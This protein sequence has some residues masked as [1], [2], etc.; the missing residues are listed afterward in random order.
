M[1]RTARAILG[2]MLTLVLLVAAA[3]LMLTRS[4]FGRD[5]I[6]LYALSALR[7]SVNGHVEIGRIEGNVLGRFSLSDVSITDSAGQPFVAA[8]R[9]TATLDAGALLLRRITLSDVVVGKPEVHLTKTPDEAWNFARIFRR[10]DTTASVSSRGFGDWIRLTSVVLR[11]GELVI[12]RP[13]APDA[14]FK[15]TLRDSVIRDAL[16]GRTRTRVDPA[17]HGLRQTM[18]FTAISAVLAQVVVADPERTGILLQFDRWPPSPAFSSPALNVRNF[19]GEVRVASDT[20]HVPRFTMRLPGTR[21]NGAFRYMLATGDGSGISG[22]IRLRSLT[23][24]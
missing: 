1:R 9:V 7:E 15:G 16:A 11:D 20:V 2:V 17:D 24:A 14:D 4:S 12:Q 18:D 22:W 21:V 8:K 3:Y 13:W 19:A 5:R 23:C 6:R 10:T